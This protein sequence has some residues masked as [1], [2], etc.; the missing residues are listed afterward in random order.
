LKKYLGILFALVLAVSLTLMPAVVAGQSPCGNPGSPCNGW[1][2]D[3]GDPD[4]SDSDAVPPE[5]QPGISISGWGPVRPGTLGGGYGG[6]DDCRVM[7]E[8]RNMDGS[9]YDP[10]TDIET[11]RCATVTYTYD[12]CVTP[13]CLEYSNLDGQAV[14]EDGHD[15]F[16]DG[17]HV[18]TYL[19]VGGPAGEIWYTQYI[20]LTGCNL[21][22]CNTHVVEFC[23]TGAAWGSFAGYGQV[24]IDWV[25]LEVGQPCECE[26]P[27]GG[28]LPATV[29]ISD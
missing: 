16:V 21:P 5:N 8:E 25:E 20:D 2:V 11:L 26:C 7:W 6:V 4:G 14:N 9:A 15:V 10:G 19:D 18:F 22:C 28:S 13:T 23:A 24:A 1:E 27:Q 17:V 12:E 3:I 29:T